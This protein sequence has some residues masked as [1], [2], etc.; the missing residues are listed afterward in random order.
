MTGATYYAILSDMYVENLGFIIGI[1]E[2]V[3]GLGYMVGPML[4]A[5]LFSLG[6]FRMPFLVLSACPLLVL[7]VLP[8]LL[9]DGHNFEPNHQ[10]AYGSPSLFRHEGTHHHDSWGEF[11]MLEQKEEGPETARSS[12]TSRVLSLPFIVV[13]LGGTLATCGFAFVEPVLSEHLMSQLGVSASTSGMLMGIPSV[14]YILAAPVA[15]WLGEK[16]GYRPVL[17]MGCCLFA[18]A[19]A[20]M[21]PS[22]IFP[23]AITSTLKWVIQVNTFLFLLSLLSSFVLRIPSPNPSSLPLSSFSPWFSHYYFLSTYA[24]VAGVGTSSTRFRFSIW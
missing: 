20:L 3:T 24:C 16:W 19:M 14:S 18:V 17:F 8:P 9:R 1:Q 10:L 4:G 15:G 5:A 11:T 2:A 23:M 12:M 13:A 22:P 21:G 6:G 7:L